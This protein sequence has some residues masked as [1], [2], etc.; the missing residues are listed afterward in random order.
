[1]KFFCLKNEFLNVPIEAP[2][3]YFSMGPIGWASNGAWASISAWTFI[4]QY[5]TLTNE[6]ASNR[7]WAS[8]VAGLL[9]EH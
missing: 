3:V 6:W 4:L 8:I 5:P 1:L 7:T 2:G 9:L